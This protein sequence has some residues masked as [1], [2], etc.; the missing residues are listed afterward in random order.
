MG[1]SWIFNFFHAKNLAENDFIDI[2][3]N[4][5]LL[6]QGIQMLRHSKQEFRN[7]FEE[8]NLHIIS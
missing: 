5:V 7:L 8:I 6:Y 1:V 2:N 4:N 3:Q